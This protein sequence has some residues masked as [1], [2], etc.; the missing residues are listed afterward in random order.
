MFCLDVFNVMEQL[1]QNKSKDKETMT[2]GPENRKR[3]SEKI[4]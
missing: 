1:V 2:F 4:P 3:L